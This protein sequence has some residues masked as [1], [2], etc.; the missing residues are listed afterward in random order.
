[1]GVITVEPFFS[2]LFIHTWFYKEFLQHI[3]G[4]DDNSL[5]NILETDTEENSEIFAP[6]IIF[7]FPYYDNDN[8]IPIL[9]KS[10]NVFSILNTN[11]KSINAKFDEFKIFIEHLK[12]MT[13][14]L[15][16]YI[17]RKAGYLKKMIHHKYNMRAI[18]VYHRVNHAVA[19][20]V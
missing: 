3:G 8:L 20:V 10:K 1:M 9:T 5:T 16:Q 19:K 7:H 18:N 12:K 4:V 13:L 2:F 6:Q 17:S 11:I 14:N 15:M